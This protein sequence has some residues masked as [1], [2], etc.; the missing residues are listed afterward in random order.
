M[1]N[2]GRSQHTLLMANCDTYPIALRGHL[3]SRARP[4]LSKM[5]SLATLIPGTNATDIT[6]KHPSYATIAKASM[7]DG[8]ICN[9]C[10]IGASLE[11]TDSNS[12][13]D[14]AQYK[15]PKL[16]ASIDIITVDATQRNVLRYATSQGAQEILEMDSSD[17]HLHSELCQEMNVSYHGY[18]KGSVKGPMYKVR[19]SAN[20]FMYEIDWHTSFPRGEHYHAWTLM[21]CISMAAIHAPLLTTREYVFQ[22]G[23]ADLL[24]TY[25]KAIPKCWLNL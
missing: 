11:L 18:I 2:V 13:D 14:Y 6:C 21:H 15:P 20:D 17:L 24:S 8:Y 7:C 16:V 9:P 1:C 25:T 12:L 19:T 5:A 22:I 4:L 23:I 3:A 10:A